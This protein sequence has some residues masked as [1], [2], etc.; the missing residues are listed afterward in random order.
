MCSLTEVRPTPARPGGM[1]ASD[2]AELE[3]RLRLTDPAGIQLQAVSAARS[4]KHAL[5]SERPANGARFP[6][7]RCGGWSAIADLRGAEDVRE[8]RWAPDAVVSHGA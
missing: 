8:V 6:G 2:G 3:A 7:A 1:G 5:S 4:C